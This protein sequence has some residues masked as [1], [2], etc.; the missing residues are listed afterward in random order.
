MFG[1]RAKLKT[2][3]RV[4]LV[5]LGLTSCTEPPPAGPSLDPVLDGR[6]G[7]H[8]IDSSSPVALDAA[9]GEASDPEAAPAVQDGVADAGR[10]A[11]LLP[12]YWLP[13]ST[14]DDIFSDRP[15]LVT[16]SGDAAMAEF[17]GAEHVLGVDTGNCNYVTVT[18]PTK[19]AIASG[20]TIKVRLW[21][22]EL[23]AREPAEAHAALLIDG[24]ELLNER[25]PIPQPGGLIVKQVR[26]EQPVP[27]GSPA[28]FHLHN[29]GANSWA[30]VEVSA[31]P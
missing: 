23:S 15:S 20:E 10:E 12:E 9:R 27:I 26:V 6:A 21:H 11:V 2:N 28:L 25:V 18:Q 31:G 14:D 19:R 5:A 16:C 22:F 1:R 17:L 29:H 24:L 3:P 30:L 7:L 13:V 4:L 8:D